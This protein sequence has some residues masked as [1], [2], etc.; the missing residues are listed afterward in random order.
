MP[1]I[2]HDKL[3]ALQKHPDAIR[4]ICLLA[5]VDHG[6]TTL[7]DRLLATNG[8]VSSRLAGKVR[9]LDS[10]PDEQERGI[11]MK[12]S[13]ISLYFKI[14]QQLVPTDASEITG[15]QSETD[16][17]KATSQQP[18]T[19]EKEF[20]INLIDSPGHVDFSSEVSVAS[21]LCDSALVLVDC[22]EG[23]ASQTVTVF[24]QAYIERVKPILV[25]NKMDRLI[26]ELKM[27]PVEAFAHLN[28]IIEQANAVMASFLIDENVRRQDM[29]YEIQKERQTDAFA[30]EEAMAQL[31]L[32]DKDTSSGGDSYFLPER[33]NV[34]FASA[35]DGWAFRTKDF[36][37]ILSQK[38]NFNEHVLRRVLWGNYYFDPKAK[39]VI[40]PN[41]LK[42]RNLKPMAV[43]FMLD[44]L[45]AVYDAVLLNPDTE[46]VD[47]MIK[48]LGLKILPQ[49]LKSKDSSVLLQ[50]MLG[51]WLPLSRSILLT[52]IEMLPSPRAA[53]EYRLDKY[54]HTSKE[55]EVSAERQ[56]I[57]QSAKQCHTETDEPIVAF[58]AKMISVPRNSITFLKTGSEMDGLS[59]EER[60][61]RRDMLIARRRAA[62]Q[63]TETSD[64]GLQQTIVSSPLTETPMDEEKELVVGIGR[65]YSG[66]LRKGQTIH[67]LQPKYDPL[68][69]EQY[70]A[71]IK[72]E[73][74]FLPMGRELDEIES[75][76][77]GNIFAIAGVEGHILKFGTLCSSPQ[78]PSLGSL[79][80]DTSTTIVRYAVEPQDPRD[81]DKLIEGLRLLNQ[82]DPCVEVV[83]QETGEHVLVTA[84]ELHL[85]RC[86][87]D[88]K[89]RF[90]RVPI[91]HSP[92]IVPY[93]ETVV[94]SQE[95]SDRSVEMQT[96]NKF[97]TIRARARQLPKEWLEFHDK[98]VER[99]RLLASDDVSSIDKESCRAF[100][101]ELKNVL[102][103]D[104]EI[105]GLV[106]RIWAFGP[107]KYGSNL[108]L[109]AIPG[110][111][112]S[113][114]L[115]NDQHLNQHEMSRFDSSIVAGFQ[116]ACNA[117]P[118][119]AEPMRGVCFIIED[120][121][122]NISES[123]GQEQVDSMK[124]IA[125]GQLIPL[126]RELL[127]QAF[128]KQS[129]R[130][131]LAMY[132]C[133]IQASAEVLGRVYGVISK[134]NGRILSEE[135]KDGHSMFVINALLPVAESFGFS[136]DIR[137]RTSGIAQP[138]LI[139]AGWE[140]LE[141]DPFWVPTT[142]EE[143]EDLGEKADRENVAKRV[144][145]AVRKRKGMFVEEKIVEH[146]EKQ[147]TMRQK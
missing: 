123:S 54:M 67:V 84:G 66:R 22:V 127:K 46:R 28:R 24:K 41:Q 109:N 85:E 104:A 39:R 110:Y 89:E 49:E 55:S 112:R 11:T 144:M 100:L 118:L 37:R 130:L 70:R 96:P 31:N 141:Q 139:F 108:L 45:W 17:S 121:S 131:M 35:I 105:A 111:E 86:L 42:G 129:P 47:K 64:Q 75:V 134:R 63:I 12:A 80:L 51:Q 72:V 18:R 99:L 5:H 2:A 76:P 33:G 88:L 103:K 124:T 106:D 60:K 102:K 68:H 145:D 137:A 50:A 32:D 23:I 27:T 133:E 1:V 135:M 26:T 25:L 73:N 53:Q 7:S 20:L 9:F 21:R 125:G 115:L 52:V 92:P 81:M 138:Q 38:L 78:F 97:I 87:R 34:I 69:P 71:E 4:N 93:R 36:A 48:S 119:C 95:K 147:K 29:L 101:D 16:A 56:L 62:E 122:F 10:R 58:V 30:T 107:R 128:L 132:S 146:A 114:W 140:M 79:N 91:A 82:A 13:A 59:E 90:A 43:Q 120:V 15:N 8:I 57:Q 77:A 3:V 126:T 94:M 142:E 117:G 143:L 98:N 19:V 65:I 40:G 14:I 136:D 83:L 44:N 6:K 116:M 61:R 74:L 113:P